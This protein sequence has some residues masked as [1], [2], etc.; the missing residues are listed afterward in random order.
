MTAQHYS[1]ERS[2]PTP[3]DAALKLIS[4]QI[5][6]GL[7]PKR[8]RKLAARLRC[9]VEAV[10]PDGRDDPKL[11]ILNDHRNARRDPALHAAEY[12]YAAARYRELDAIASFIET[13][14]R[15]VGR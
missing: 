5:A 2:T 14:A 9:V 12:E 4:D 10:R 11:A 6:T 3:H 1:A 13:A 7:K 15:R 8:A